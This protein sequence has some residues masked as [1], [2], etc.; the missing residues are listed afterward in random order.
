[1]HHIVHIHLQDRSQRAHIQQHTKYTYRACDVW[2][3]YCMFDF[4]SSPQ[5]H[6][7]VPQWK[8]QGNTALRPAWGFNHCSLGV[9]IRNEYK[10]YIVI[11]SEL[12]V[13]DMHFSSYSTIHGSISSKNKKKQCQ[14]L[15]W[16]VLFLRFLSSASNCNVHV[17]ICKMSNEMRT[18]SRLMEILRPP[19]GSDP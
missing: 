15:Q 6:H 19:R 2:S 10:K 9:R 3:I 13:C 17:N 7:N 11:Y 5:C 16:G 12:C 1:M 4:F 8:K 14:L 18:R